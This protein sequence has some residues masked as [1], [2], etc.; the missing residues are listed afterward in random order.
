MPVLSGVFRIGRDAEVRYSPSGDAVANL[1]VAYN[2]GRKDDSGNRPTQWIDAGLWGERAAKLS[3]YLLKGTAVELVIEDLHMEVY[4]GRDGDTRAKIAGRIMKIEFAGKSADD[5]GEDRTQ[6]SSRPA[7]AAP[8]S[9]PAATAGGS[10]FED[11][12]DDIPF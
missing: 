12:D 10:G 5:R 2:Y 9:R 11:M 7:A 1:S 6:P 4:K 3:Q 8:A